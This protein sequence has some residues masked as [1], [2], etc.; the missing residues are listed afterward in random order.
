VLANASHITNVPGRKT[1]V[2]DAKWIADL[3]APGLIRSNFVRLLAIQELRDLTRTR[4]E[5]APEVSQHNLRIE[6][7][8]EDANWKLG[9]VRVGC[10]SLATQVPAT[11][12]GFP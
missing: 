6:K 9:S 5:A 2:N 12:C 3:L 11:K 7:I 4:K 8:R 1:D 10:E